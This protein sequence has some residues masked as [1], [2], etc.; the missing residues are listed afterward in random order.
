MKR[1]VLCRCRV[2]I[3]IGGVAFAADGCLRGCPRARPYYFT[4]MPITTGRDREEMEAGLKADYAAADT[5]G[6]NCLGPAEVRAEMSGVFGVTAPASPLVDWDLDGC[7]DLREFKRRRI[8]I[9]T[10]QIGQRTDAF[11]RPSCAV[12]DA[13]G[14]ACRGRRVTSRRKERAGIE[15][16]PASSARQFRPV[17]ILNVD[18]GVEREPDHKSRLGSATP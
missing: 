12:V 13:A 4:S 5:N 14:S 10:W 3:A 6:D 15:H 11:R 2:A 9:S 1:I 7:V 17:A 8:P 16:K 18:F